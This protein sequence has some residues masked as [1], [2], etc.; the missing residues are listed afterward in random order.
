MP[1]SKISQSAKFVAGSTQPARSS[2]A[3]PL[4][5]RPHLAAPPAA[6]AAADPCAIHAR[7]CRSRPRTRDGNLALTCS[8]GRQLNRVPLSSLHCRRRGRIAICCATYVFEEYG[9]AAA[10]PPRKACT[11]SPRP[12]NAWCTHRGSAHRH[13]A[14]FS[15]S[16]APRQPPHILG[17]RAR[18]PGARA[19]RRNPEAMCGA[20]THSRA[21]NRDEE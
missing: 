18:H 9:A 8:A 13:G 17:R 16:I 20:R 10:N 12:G 4:A 15:S 2:P 3:V 1:C 5:L 11:V 21:S 7:L 14:L 19:V 6:G